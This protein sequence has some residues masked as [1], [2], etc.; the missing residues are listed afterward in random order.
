MEI[1]QHKLRMKFKAETDFDV[2][3]E[4]MSEYTHWLELLKV[5]EISKEIAYENSNLKDTVQ[6]AID[7]L[8]DGLTARYAK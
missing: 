6:K 4:N 2:T 5:D 8:D 1:R 3:E 7:I